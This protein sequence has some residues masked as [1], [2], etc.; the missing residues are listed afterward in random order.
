MD[1][2]TALDVSASGLSAER[3]QLNITAMNLAN[4]KTTR[5]PGDIGPVP[6][7]SGRKGSERP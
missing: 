1:F 5:M 2:M 4:A 7:K 6:Q 3:T